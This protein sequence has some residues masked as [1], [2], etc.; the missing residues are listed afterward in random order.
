MGKLLLLAGL[1]A[2]VLAVVSLFT[3]KAGF[4]LKKKTRFKACIGYIII[5]AFCM[6]VGN[7][8]LE[9]GGKSDN[10]AAQLPAAIAEASTINTQ[11]DTPIIFEYREQTS[12]PRKTRHGRVD[13]GL[14]YIY[15]ADQNRQLTSKNIAST[16][17]AAAKFYINK[18]SQE[19]GEID[20]MLV[21]VTDMPYELDEYKNDY[22]TAKSA[23]WASAIFFIRAQTGGS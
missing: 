10:S 15:P 17:V 21:V 18:Y 1:A 19:Y 6:G 14:I 13:G 7:D 3:P 11:A 9:R 22:T 2:M 23:S 16:C 20:N 4:F 8:I 5:A 12:T